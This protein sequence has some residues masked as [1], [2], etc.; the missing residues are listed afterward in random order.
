MAK[1]PVKKTK[2]ASTKL[3]DEQLAK[4]VRI[5]NIAHEKVLQ[6]EMAALQHRIT[7]GETLLACKKSVGHSNWMIWLKENCP[8]IS[9][10]TA[11]DYM[12]LAKKAPDIEKAAKEN[13]QLVSDLSLRAAKELL[14]DEE[15]DEEEGEEDQDE[16]EEQDDDDDASSNLSDQLKNAGGEKVY[17]ALPKVEQQK[18]ADV[19]PLQ[20]VLENR[21]D[22]ELCETICKMMGPDR[23]IKIASGI[24]RYVMGGKDTPQERLRAYAAD[25]K[26]I[27][28]AVI[29]PEEEEQ[30]RDAA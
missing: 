2:K 29:P 7:A 5:I 9:D 23:L 8:D 16:D 10:R 4:N 15:D 19:L 11:R 12:W 6:S 26:Q 3:S 25:I 28:D 18:L 20:P 17:Q 14:K 30:Q 24:V 22:R 1:K 27:C 21:S 13:R